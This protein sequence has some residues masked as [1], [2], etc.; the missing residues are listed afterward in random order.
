VCDEFSERRDE[1][2]VTPLPTDNAHGPEIDRAQISPASR[3][4]LGNIPDYYWDE[5]KKKYFKIT[6][7][8]AIEVS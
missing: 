2:G 8:K 6:I 1:G 4:N 3:M 7:V 5:E